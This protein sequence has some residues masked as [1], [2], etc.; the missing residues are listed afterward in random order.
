MP[1][2]RFK[3][4]EFCG[5]V[6]ILCVLMCREDREGCKGLKKSSRLDGDQELSDSDRVLRVAD[7]PRWGRWRGQPRLG[8]S[9]HVNLLL[10]GDVSSDTG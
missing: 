8:A 10:F 7:G 3:L 5:C 1:G 9:D 2:G 4:V 6:V